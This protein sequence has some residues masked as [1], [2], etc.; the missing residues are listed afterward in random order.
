MS[1]NEL[2]DKMAY[3]LP[4]KNKIIFGKELFMAPEVYFNEKN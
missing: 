2:T 1:Y 3:E 4:D